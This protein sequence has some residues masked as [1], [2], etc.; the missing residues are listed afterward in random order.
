MIAGF[1]LLDFCS[2]DT[3]IGSIQKNSGD[4]KYLIN[5]LGTAYCSTPTSIQCQIDSNS[6]VIDSQSL[7]VDISG[8]YSLGIKGNAKVYYYDYHIEVIYYVFFPP[9]A[10]NRIDTCVVYMD[11]D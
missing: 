7:C 6:V 4:R 5:G 9:M 2:S 10:G 8:I 11:K 1:S 3:S